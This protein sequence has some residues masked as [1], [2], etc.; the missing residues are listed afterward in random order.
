MCSADLGLYTFTWPKEENFTFLDAHSQSPR[1]C[2]DWTQV[3]DWSMKRKISLVPTVL[4][5]EEA[6]GMSPSD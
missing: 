6:P 1:K 2:V 3:E 4:F 5:P